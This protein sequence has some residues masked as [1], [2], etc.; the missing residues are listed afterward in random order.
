[1]Y[2]DK[3]TGTERAFVD[4]DAA[5]AFAAQANGPM[6]ATLLARGHLPDEK[7]RLRDEMVEYWVESEPVELVGI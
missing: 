6:E 2:S 4:R 5:I 7:W 3:T 1:M